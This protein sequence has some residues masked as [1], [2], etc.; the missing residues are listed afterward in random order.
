M[1]N[2][3]FSTL[4][5]MAS[6][7][8]MK[9]SGLFSKI[10]IAKYLSPSDYGL[11]TF[12]TISLPGMFTYLTNFCLHDMLSHAGRGK[13]YFS[14]ALIYSTI[15]TVVIVSSI[16]AFYQQF[17]DFLNLPTNNW[18]FL[19]TIFFISLFSTSIA[20]N[21]T[22]FFRGQKMYNTTSIIASLPPIIK[23]ALILIVLNLWDLNVEIALVLF[24]FST[25]IAVLFILLRYYNLI[26]PYF[27]EIKIPPRDMIYFGST[28]LV[29]GLFSNLTLILSRVVVAHNLG[30]EFQG[31]LDTSL[32]IMAILSISFSAMR[33]IS[34]PE[35]TSLSELNKESLN[36]TGLIDVVKFLFSL[37]IFITIILAF[38]SRD[39]VQ[40]L[41]SE[42]Y[43]KASKYLYLLSIGYI[44]IFIQQFIAYVNISLE[45]NKTK[46]LIIFTII[47]ILV[48][49][50][51]AHIF[52]LLF[53]FPGVYYSLTTLFII[54]TM[55]TIL[56]TKN[57]L[58]ILLIIKNIH[59]LL[60]CSFV[61][62]LIVYYFPHNVVTVII[63]FLLFEILIFVVGYLDKMLLI[64]FFERYIIKDMSR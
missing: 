41:Y 40:L 2:L 29:L 22:G 35:V 46:S 31:Y 62:V 32:T 18:K 56:T 51:L 4:F 33:F 34:I 42:K 43:I 49:P 64:R 12:L 23:F 54:Y 52:I 9:L 38:Y 45:I 26:S 63:S 37:L 48:S 16:A 25:F 30:M 17:F 13:N 1:S 19:L 10:L 8:L 44:F 57:S 50:I 55:I 47:L 21:I 24:S 7:I 53:G 28:V 11:V 36:H 61:I 5:F 3:Y 27:F 6:I 60:F 14:F 59:K 58:P 20:N 39:L 15:L